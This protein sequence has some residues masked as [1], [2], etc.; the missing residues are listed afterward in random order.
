MPSDPDTTCTSGAT[1]T[2]PE[3]CQVTD[4]GKG[5]LLDETVDESGDPVDLAPD[6]PFARLERLPAALHHEDEE[7]RAEGIRLFDR[8]VRASY[9][10]RSAPGARSSGPKASVIIASK[11]SIPGLIGGY[12]TLLA[13]LL[14]Q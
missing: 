12:L 3:T 11:S 9:A 7:V 4:A 8:Y 1:R 13:W 2:T 5:D 6:R 10:R 14:G